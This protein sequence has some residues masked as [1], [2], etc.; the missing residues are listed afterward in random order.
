MNVKLKK[1]NWKCKTE[2]RMN[3]NFGKGS[4]MIKYQL[5]NT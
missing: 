4:M 2:K 3:W 5:S 1:R